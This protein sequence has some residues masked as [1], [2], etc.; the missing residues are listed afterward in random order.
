MPAFMAE[1]SLSFNAVERLARANAGP[2]GFRHGRAA[3]RLAGLQEDGRTSDGRI[4][5]SGAKPGKRA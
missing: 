2:E 3:W 1:T 5:R 4:A